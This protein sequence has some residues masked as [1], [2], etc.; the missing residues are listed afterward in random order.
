MA[1]AK[2]TLSDA[3]YQKKREEVMRRLAE[4]REA[5]AAAAKRAEEAKK[6]KFEAAP[7][8]RKFGTHTGITCDGCAVQPIL[9]YRWRCRIC[10]N[11]DL[12]DACY[13]VFKT[14]G[15]L[16]HVNS[17]R[18]PISTIPDRHEFYALAEQGCFKGLNSGPGGATRKPTKK[19]KP[20]EPCPCGSGKKYKKCCR[21]SE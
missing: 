13:D 9:G 20:N 6:K 15:K 21:V 19:I 3:E 11:H 12:C 2:A 8:A 5:Q 10:K 7:E 1:D 14:E 16:L 18:N 4:A 17:R